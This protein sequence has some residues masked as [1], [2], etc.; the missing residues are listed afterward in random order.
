METEARGDDEQDAETAQGTPTYSKAGTLHLIWDTAG[1]FETEEE[2][3]SFEEQLSTFV[4]NVPEIGNM[5]DSLAIYWRS[6]IR[7]S[8]LTCEWSSRSASISLPKLLLYKITPLLLRLA[9]QMSQKVNELWIEGFD[10]EHDNYE[11]SPPKLEDVLQAFN[12]VGYWRTSLTSLSVYDCHMSAVGDILEDDWTYPE[13][14]EMLEVGYPKNRRCSS[15][16]LKVAS[17]SCNLEC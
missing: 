16:L 1:V 11:V 4:Q 12:F 14:L 10:L 8:F 17:R 9:A 7:V 2:R 15:T 6:G 3:I 5:D 13:A